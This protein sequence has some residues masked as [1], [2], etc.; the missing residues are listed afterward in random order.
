MIVECCCCCGGGAP[1]SCTCELCFDAL[2]DQLTPDAAAEE[3]RRYSQNTICR[4]V[5]TLRREKQLVLR[6][7]ELRCCTNCYSKTPATTPAERQ[8]GQL[9]Q[10]APAWP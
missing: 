1:S 2:E 7:D 8:P 10:G 6:S 3:A 9:C 4:V 5:K